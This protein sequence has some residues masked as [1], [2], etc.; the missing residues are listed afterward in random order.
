VLLPTKGDTLTGTIRT[1]TSPIEQIVTLKRK[2][3]GLDT[4]NGRTAGSSS[5]GPLDGDDGDHRRGN[6]R[7]LSTA[8]LRVVTHGMEIPDCHQHATRDAPM[9][10]R[11][12]PMDDL[13]NPVA[14]PYEPEEP[15]VRPH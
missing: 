6:L 8:E 15:E 4:V 11:P 5:S 3:V 9:P 14:E 13:L 2:L 7:P 12:E 10:P 1:L